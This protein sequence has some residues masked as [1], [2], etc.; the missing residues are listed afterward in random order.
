MKY[1]KLSFSSASTFL[2]Y[3]LGG[4]D[5]AIKWLL[6]VIALDYFTGM[7]KAFKNKSLSSEVG[8]KGIAKKVYMLVLVALAVVIDEVIGKS[9]IIRNLVIYYIIA[10][11]GLSILENGTE[12][13]FP[14]PKI[15]KDSLEQIKK[16]E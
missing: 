7:I 10:N 13:G 4:Y 9:G 6:I 12:L 16:G 15:L 3:L 5:N 1:L 8:A 11:E 14:T 2:F